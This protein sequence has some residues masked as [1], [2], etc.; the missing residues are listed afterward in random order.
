MTKSSEIKIREK[1]TVAAPAAAVWNL[2]CDPYAVANCLAGAAIDGQREDGS[3]DASMVLHFGPLK[4]SF[5]AH[6]ILAIDADAMTGTI[7]TRGKDAHGGVRVTATTRFGVFANENAADILIDADVELGGK[8]ASVIGAGA[9]IVAKKLSAVFTE[10]LA[11]AFAQ[12]LDSNHGA[13][14]EGCTA[15]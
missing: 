8:L 14:V 9:S 13:L 5:R 2:I 10:K 7:L 11:L 4:V 1:I 15:Q 12:S 3:Y 6:V